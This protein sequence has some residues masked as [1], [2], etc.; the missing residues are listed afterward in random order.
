MFK[1]PVAGGILRTLRQ[2]YVPGEEIDI[3]RLEDI[4]DDEDVKTLEDIRENVKL[5]GKTEQIYEDCV[6]RLKNDG[7]KEREQQLL[8]SISMADSVTDGHLIDEMMK[9]LTQIQKQLRGK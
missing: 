6:K 9:E 5:A 8:A 3:K 7:L 1:T 2:I 4:L